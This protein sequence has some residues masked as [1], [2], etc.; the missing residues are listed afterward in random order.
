MLA[1]TEERRRYAEEV[2]KAIQRIGRGPH[3]A[4][5][6]LLRFA[7]INLNSLSQGQLSDLAAELSAFARGKVKSKAQ[8]ALSRELSPT[9]HGLWLSDKM[10]KNKGL[11][12]GT[13]RKEEFLPP[14]KTIENLHATI[15]E[16]IEWYAVDTAH[17]PSI[18]LTLSVPNPQKTL[19]PGLP[20]TESKK[21]SV[22]YLEGKA[23][24]DTFYYYA[25]TLLAE[26]GPRIKSCSVCGTLFAAV[27]ADQFFC[28]SKCLNRATQQR[29][30]E[31]RKDKER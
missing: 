27:R 17:F 5:E 21:R 20:E 10:I 24:E 7:Q 2:Q 16:A 6:W 14:K 26:Y 31:R 22:L 4:I 9:H 1:M 23:L 8:G 3:S 12:G 25:A 18:Q 13:K 11:L 29:F 30:R 19:V 28:S 15:A